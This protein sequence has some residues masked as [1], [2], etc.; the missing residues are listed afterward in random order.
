MNSMPGNPY[1]GP[2]IAKTADGK[3]VAQALIALAYEQRTATLAQAA[4]LGIA[5]D[6]N[7]LE[8]LRTE[9]RDRLGM[10]EAAS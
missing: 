1:I 5:A 10:D 6:S 4:S 3:V 8:R 9:I 2:F 7:E